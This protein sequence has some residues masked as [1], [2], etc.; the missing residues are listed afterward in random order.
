MLLNT[1]VTLPIAAAST[2]ATQETAGVYGVA[3]H[4]IKAS[5]SD[6]KRAL[7]GIRRMNFRL[8]LFTWARPVRA[9]GCGAGGGGEEGVAAACCS[10]SR[11]SGV[12][13]LHR[14]AGNWA[15]ANRRT[16]RDRFGRDVGCSGERRR[17]TGANGSLLVSRRLMSTRR[18]GRARYKRARCHAATGHARRAPLTWPPPP[19]ANER[20]A[21]A[22]RDRRREPIAGPPAAT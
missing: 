13:S 10:R 7:R 5:V 20:W 14:P 9:Q 8:P 17:L 18:H 1:H 15:L 19:P 12:G 4:A 22:S 2:A 21:R 6:V 16:P 11:A 3:S